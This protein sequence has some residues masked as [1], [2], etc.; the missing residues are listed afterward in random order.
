MTTETDIGQTEDCVGLETFIND[1]M[2]MDYVENKGYC[3]DYYPLAKQAFNAL[4]DHQRSLFTSNSAYLTEYTRLAKWAEILGD[5]FN[6]N[7]ILEVGLVNPNSL[8]NNDS[9]SMTTVIV[10]SA[11]SV[12][13]ASLLLIIKKKKR[14]K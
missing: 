10:I 14:S 9:S 3:E 4:N 12:L 11:F 8:D 7:N 1:Y 6:S 2:H 5:E 13:S